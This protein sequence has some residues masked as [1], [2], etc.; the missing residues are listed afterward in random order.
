M[1]FLHPTSTSADTA[2]ERALAFVLRHRDTRVARLPV[3]EGEADTQQRLDLSWVPVR[4]WKA[5]TNRH[6]RDMPVI[7]VDR[8]YLE[9]C[10]LSCVVMELKSGDLFIEGSEQYSDYRTQLV[11]WEVYAQDASTYCEQVGI[12]SD[13][14]QF[15]QHLQTWLAETIRTT[16]ATFPTN[17]ALTI[18]DGEPVLRRL[19][20]Q[21]EPEGFAVIDQLLSE[22]MPEC[23]IVDILTDT[24][25]W[26]NWTAAFGP[27]SG[28]DS[29]LL[30][31]RPP[32]RHH[33]LLL[34]LLSGA[35]PNRTVAPRD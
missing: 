20:K 7:T 33:H 35:D 14:A 22:R 8:K 3:S 34:W 10:V 32:L 28:F 27:L 17:T 30:S 23:T 29:R 26:L 19:D 9:L 18:T 6:R 25:H 16:D 5:V 24:E 1:A 11:S 31:P 2:L 4:W 21:P 12:A 13:P 15:V